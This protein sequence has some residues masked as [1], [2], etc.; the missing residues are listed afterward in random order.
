MKELMLDIKEKLNKLYEIDDDSKIYN[1][2]RDIDKKLKVIEYKEKYGIEL[3]ERDIQGDNIFIDRLYGNIRIG[4]VKEILNSVEQPNED[5]ILI[6]FLYPTGPYIF[7]GGCTFFGGDNIYDRETFESFFNELKTYKFKYIDDLNSCLYFDI[8]NGMKLFK[9][10]EDIC[11]KYQDI[12]NK[13]AKEKKKDY[14]KKQLADLESKG[15]SN[16]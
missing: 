10:Y 3:Q 15:E 16:E 13:K 11:K 1:F 12:W 7:G 14:L 4:K 9:D 5:E 6:E 8:E 2:I